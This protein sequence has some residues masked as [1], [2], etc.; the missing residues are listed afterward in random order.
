[1][2]KHVL[3]VDPNQATLDYLKEKLEAPSLVIRVAPGGIEALAKLSEEPF[4]LVICALEM[5]PPNG[6]GLMTEMQSRGHK[7]PI[8]FLSKSYVGDNAVRDRL[9]ALGPYVLMDKPVHVNRLFHAVESALGVKVDWNETRGSPRLPM[10]LELHLTIRGHHDT[11]IPM[12]AESVD[13][14]LSGVCFLRTTCDVCTGYE[15]GGVHADCVLYKYALKNLKG[16]PLDMIIRVS[17]T[18]TLR[19]RGRVVHTLIEEGTTREYVGA[20]FEGLT[21]R[22]RERLRELLKKEGAAT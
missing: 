5:P 10:H 3:V 6:M 13:L 9:A 11:R 8:I 21:D 15:R 2:R 16:R 14:S 19:L 4:D 18:E 1:M 22:Q 7:T 20:V 17:D 12:R